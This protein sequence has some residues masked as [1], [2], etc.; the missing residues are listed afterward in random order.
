MTQPQSSTLTK[1]VVW[2]A[3]WGSGI[4]EWVR[5]VRDADKKPI[6]FWDDT[7]E[8]IVIDTFRVRDDEGDW[9]ILTMDSVMQTL[10]KL[11]E[12]NITHCGDLTL[13]PYDSDQCFPNIVLQHAI[14]GEMV[15]DD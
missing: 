7:G 8:P 1:D 11:Q 9:H 12:S 4:P 3:L 10:K 15:F 2:E 6:S 5:S 13:D 14:F